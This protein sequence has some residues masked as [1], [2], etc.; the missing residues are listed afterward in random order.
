MLHTLKLSVENLNRMVR[1][2]LPVLLLFVLGYTIT[3][4]AVLIIIGVADGEQVVMREHYGGDPR[5]LYEVRFRVNP[6]ASA[7]IDYQELVSL[8]ENH[9]EIIRGFAFAPTTLVEPDHLLLAG[10]SYTRNPN[11]PPLDEGRLFSQN[12]LIN[13][14]KVAIVGPNVL[15]VLEGSEEYVEAFGERWR[16]IGRIAET[17]PITGRSL[18]ALDHALILPLRYYANIVSG[19]EFD[20][21]VHMFIRKLSKT[22]RD[23]LERSLQ[24]I[25][26]EHQ[27]DFSE[28]FNASP[29]K[30]AELQDLIIVVAI[31]MGVVGFALFNVLA[32]IK[33][34]IRRRTYEIAVRLSV[35]ASR[36]SVRRMMLCEQVMIVVISF[37][38]GYI[39]FRLTQPFIVRTGLLV[40]ESQLQIIIVALIALGMSVVVTLFS[41]REVD[42]M[43]LVQVLRKAEM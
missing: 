23:Q 8:I 24:Q 10:F 17:S 3:I 2:Q 6:D 4:A 35:G 15:S 18:N 38:V 29:W 43:D 7:G 30:T 22:G 9:S 31:G 20:T 34:W 33:Y 5:Q 13:G 14:E 42:R 16:V 36:R 41:T 32:L 25:A 40:G 11:W 39:M 19:T 1:S 26:G 12:E 37:C 28:F 27:V 21:N